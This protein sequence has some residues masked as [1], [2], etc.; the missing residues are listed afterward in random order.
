MLQFYCEFLLGNTF[1]FLL[2]TWYASSI[3]RLVAYLTGPMAVNGNSDSSG[4]L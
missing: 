3:V 1:A 4:D 2:D